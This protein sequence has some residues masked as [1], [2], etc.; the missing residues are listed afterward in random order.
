MAVL[1][2]LF[3]TIGWVSLAIYL[4]SLH[5]LRNKK[6]H[7]ILQ[8]FSS[9]ID[10]ITVILIVIFAVEIWTLFAT[11]IEVLGWSLLLLLL[12]KVV[13]TVVL[14]IL[15]MASKTDQQLQQTLRI[16]QIT[17]FISVLF[18]I[19]FVVVSIILSTK[20][21]NNNSNKSQ[22][23]QQ[24]NK[25]QQ[26]LNNTD[27]LKDVTDITNPNKSQQQQLNN[28]KTDTLKDVTDIT[29]P[30]KSQ[31]QQQL[32]NNN[33]D[34]LKAKI[35]QLENELQTTKSQHINQIKKL[36]RKRISPKTLDALLD[37]ISKQLEPFGIKAT[38]KHHYY[39]KK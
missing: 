36:K 29:N 11:D 12:L 16:L 9:N 8:T 28:T 25:L 6:M 1:L 13:S 34:A 35:K 5:V 21:N 27:T 26:Q 22:Q 4:L 39:P 10:A 37:R 7:H 3:L 17:S 2:Y 30:N 33:T 24:V 38:H 31:Q 18:W 32:S 19:I 23:Q 15:L 14:V 20:H